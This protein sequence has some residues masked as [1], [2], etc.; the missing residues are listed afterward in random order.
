MAENKSLQLTGAQRVEGMRAV[1]CSMKNS[2][3]LLLALSNPRNETHFYVQSPDGQTILGNPRLKIFFFA[4]QH[5]F[6][7]GAGSSPEQVHPVGKNRVQ[8]VIKNSSR[9]QT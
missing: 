9:M 4:A 8:H 7:P 3:V 2:F 6:L 1:C 5:W